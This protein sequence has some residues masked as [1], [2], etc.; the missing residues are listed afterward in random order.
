MNPGYEIQEI[1]NEILYNNEDKKCKYKIISYFKITFMDN[2]ITFLKAESNF[3]DLYFKKTDKLLN[4]II[5]DIL[6]TVAEK[7]DNKGI[8]SLTVIP[9]CMYEPICL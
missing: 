5:K 8:L 4:Y 7:F 9:K 1:I 6:K 3:S 2:S